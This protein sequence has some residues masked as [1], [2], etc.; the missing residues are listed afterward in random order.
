MTVEAEQYDR[1][2]RTAEIVTSYLSRNQVQSIDLPSLIQTVHGKLVELTTEVPDKVEAVQTLTSAAIKRSIT[3]DYLVSFE[4]GKRYKTLRR[5][6]LG[7]GLTP[8][9]YRAKW[10]LPSDYPM[11]AAGYSAHRA[12]LAR[13]LGLGKLRWSAKDAASTPVAKSKAP[14]VLTAQTSG[15]DESADL[16][17]RE[18]IEDGGAYE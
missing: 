2:V 6:L 12:E 11:V 8:E 10:G 17:A 3:S 18:P 5:H 14:E 9:S 4:D 7:R 15:A 1:L 16:I 13:S